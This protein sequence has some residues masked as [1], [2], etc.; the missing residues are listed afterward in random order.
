MTSRKAK[1]KTTPPKVSGKKAGREAEQL[2]REVVRAHERRVKAAKKAAKTRERNRK[3]AQ[4]AAAAK[5]KASR[6]REK[7]ELNWHTQFAKFAAGRP[8]SIVKR[9]QMPA[10][11]NVPKGSDEWNQRH[12]IANDVVQG[13][14]SGM[15]FRNMYAMADAR[16]IALT[17]KTMFGQ[18]RSALGVSG[19]LDVFDAMV[20]PEFR[21]KVK[22]A[23]REYMRTGDFNAFQDALNQAREEEYEAGRERLS[24][25]DG[26]EG[27]AVV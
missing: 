20:S 27:G 25:S 6:S 11:A 19:N 24:D 22:K 13:S 17:N 16:G 23:A 14:I 2:A 1:L 5:L 4:R 9:L 15:F 18:A 10:N 12:K 3:A 7:L 8:N 21:D 26:G